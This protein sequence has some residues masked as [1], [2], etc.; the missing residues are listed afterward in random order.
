GS[1]DHPAPRKD[2]KATVTFLVLDD[3]DLDAGIL[4]YFDDPFSIVCAI[5]PHVPEGA[6]HRVSPHQDRNSAVTILN[7]GRRDDERQHH[8][9]DVNEDM[10][11][12]SV[13]LLSPVEAPRATVA[14]GLDA[15]AVDNAS[16]RFW[17]SSLCNS[18]VPH[19]RI[20]DPLNRA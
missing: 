3:L 11:L 2:G 5:G 20:M 19:E 1:L 18:N 14:A 4:L 17:I 12:A 9:E 6:V 7:V 16:R 15:L 13:D 10:A 8:S